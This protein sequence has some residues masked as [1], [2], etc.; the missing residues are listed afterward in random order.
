MVLTPASGDLRYR[1]LD[2][3][4]GLLRADGSEGRYAAREGWR[5][6]GPTVASAT[7]GPCPADRLEFEITDGPGGT[8]TRLDLPMQD[9]RFASDGLTLRGRLV[10]P[11]QAHG[12]VPLAVL[13]HGSE[14]YSGVDIYPKQYL[15]PAQ[16]VA[17][18]VYNKRGTGGSEGDYTQDFH[19]LAADA[20]AALQAAQRLRP[21]GFSRKGF[22]GSS[23]GGWIAPLAASQADVDYVVAEYG[24][25]ETA[26]AEDR[27]Q[28]MDDLRAAGHGDDVL[29]KAR[30][31]TDATALLMVSGF[32]RGF[33]ELS[34]V[35][36]KY[37]AEPWF[38]DIRGE[39]TGRVLEMPGWLP[40]WVARAI[41][42]RYDVNTSWGYEPL[43]VLAALA[44]PQLWVIAGAD[45]EAPNAETLR[46]IRLL[47]SQ[48]AP[49]DLAVFPDTDHGIYEFAAGD[50]ERVMLRH[51]P[52][53][54]RL[55]A[56]WI[57]RPGL[58]GDFGSAVLEPAATP[59]AAPPD[60]A[61][62]SIADPPS[63]ANPKSRRPSLPGASP[64]G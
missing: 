19:V 64:D 55:L 12:P 7:F 3:R 45:L 33:D 32:T 38:A 44:V 2:G 35:R 49:V 16:G 27:E 30:E 63:A 9:T 62:E 25:A 61:R 34:R 28:V 6:E 47:Q 36:R 58:D 22:L 53:Y 50:G 15:L 52:G 48:G 21:E 41:F 46:R 20:N 10:M 54:L 39:F 18:F 31:V 29:T 13:V 11:A 1:F 26:L 56:E 5:K 57:R 14:D 60:P 24:L 43:P 40:Q 42:S 4:T 23:Q 8:A 59:D 37:G 51:P 17:V